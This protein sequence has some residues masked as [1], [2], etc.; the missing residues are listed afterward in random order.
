MSL[1]APVC[2]TATRTDNPEIEGK[3]SKLNL[4]FISRLGHG[5]RMLSEEPFEILNK[6]HNA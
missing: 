3:P 4:L 2:R 1:P 5:Q 6:Q